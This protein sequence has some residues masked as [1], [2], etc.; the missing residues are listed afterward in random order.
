M[1]WYY[2]DDLQAYNC[3]KYKHMFHKGYGGKYLMSPGVFLDKIENNLIVVMNTYNV[4]RIKFLLKVK[5][6]MK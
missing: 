2:V 5:E 4:I 1:L 3:G 6:Y